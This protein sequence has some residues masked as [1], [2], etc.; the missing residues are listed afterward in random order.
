MAGKTLVSRVTAPSAGMGQNVPIARHVK[1]VPSGKMS[2][3]QALPEELST[4]TGCEVQFQ[5][6]SDNE[7]ACFEMKIFWTGPYL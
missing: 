2:T 6:W 7:C 4:G 5:I 3:L 1:T